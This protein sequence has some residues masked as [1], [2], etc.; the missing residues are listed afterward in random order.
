MADIAIQLG[1]DLDEADL[2]F[3]TDV[4]ARYE[5]LW[6]EL[7]EDPVIA[8]DERHLIRARIKR[9]NDL[10]FEVGDV[11]L[12][13]DESGG[14]RV[15]MLVT[16]GGRNY[17]SNRLRQLTRIDAS[18]NQARQILSDLHYH[19]ARDPF[20]SAPTK[21]L[22]AMMWRVQVFEPLMERI[23]HDVPHIEPVQAYTDFLHHRFNLS[24]SQGR[25]VPSAEAYVNWA[26]EGFPGYSLEELAER[27]N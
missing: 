25:D 8:S 19:R 18:E 13:P 9:L 17:H 27:H 23:K 11:S 10:G 2:D 4:I 21:D 26:E 1:Q 22:S 3:G 24:Y 20:R 12:I 6:N 14:N 15:R 16:V 5:E 7:R